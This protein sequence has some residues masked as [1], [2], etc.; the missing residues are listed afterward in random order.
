MKGYRPMRTRCQSRIWRN[1]SR[2]DINKKWLMTDG[3]IVGGQWGV[4]ENQSKGVR[5]VKN[6]RG[7]SGENG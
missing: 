3:V 7:G 2:G 5:R 6:G 4:G 1:K